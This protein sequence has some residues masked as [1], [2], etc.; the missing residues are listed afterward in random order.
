MSAIGSNPWARPMMQPQFG[1]A[2][3]QVSQPWQG[4]APWQ[5]QS[6]SSFYMQSQAPRYP[7]QAAPTQGIQQNFWNALNNNF[8]QPAWNGI[9]QGAQAVGNMA[10][11]HP[12][13][14]TGAAAGLGGAAMGCPYAA[15]AGLVSAAAGYMMNRAQ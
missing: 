3:Q 1:G 11:Q 14:F 4:Q 2:P 5:T 7:Q 15:G 13:A 12:Y 9:K 10:A 6:P 8:V